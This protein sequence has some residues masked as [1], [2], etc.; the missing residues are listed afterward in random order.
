M[1]ALAIV[2]GL[3]SLGALLVFSGSSSPPLAAVP[4]VAS[5]PPPPSVASPP[6]P[7]EEE[8]PDPFREPYSYRRYQT[9]G[10]S[11]D[12]LGH[13]RWRTFHPPPAHRWPLS[14]PSRP[15]SGPSGP[16]DDYPSRFVTSL[17]AGPRPT[18]QSPAGDHLAYVGQAIPMVYG[19]S[20]DV[21]GL[22]IDQQRT[23][24]VSDRYQ[25]LIFLERRS[26]EIEDGDVIT[27]PG[28]TGSWK[29]TLTSR[30]RFFAM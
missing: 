6:Y 9:L 17:P 7:P 18:I 22:Y 5:V 24:W 26:M 3:A 23:Y 19:E 4:P 10:P 28:R 27:I 16:Y 13:P 12:L 29:V 8:G 21:Y 2:A 20:S 25:N 14:G 11:R 15:L 1:D 30:N